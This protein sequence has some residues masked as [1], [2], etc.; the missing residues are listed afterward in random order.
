MIWYLTVMLTYAGLDESQFTKWQAH[1][2]KDDQE[3]H[4]FVYDNKVLLVDGLLE[5]FRNVNGNELI[6]FEFYCQGETLQ[7]V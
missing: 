5:K 7:E 4:K 6:S 3:C 1:T 2:F